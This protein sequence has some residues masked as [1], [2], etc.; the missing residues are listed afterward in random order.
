MFYA[1]DGEG[2]NPRSILMRIADRKSS[3]VM[4]QAQDLDAAAAEDLSAGIAELAAINHDI[5]DAVREYG[6]PS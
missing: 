6:Y 3:L 5:W 4:G 2:A 1:F